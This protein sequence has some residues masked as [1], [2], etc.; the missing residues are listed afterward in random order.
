MAVRPEEAGYVVARA[1]A[2]DLGFKSCSSVYS[3]CQR[4][5]FIKF[6]VSHFLIYENE[7]IIVFTVED[8]W[9]S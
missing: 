7:V 3:L 9:A 4:F 8:N 2:G 5:Q 1:R 6:S